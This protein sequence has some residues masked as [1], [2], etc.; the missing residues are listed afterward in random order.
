MIDKKK[1][2]Q[3]LSIKYYVSLIIISLASSNKKAA[4]VLSIEAT[5]VGEDQ[6]CKMKVFYTRKL[7]S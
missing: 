1:L 6:L 4:L 7:K 2:E 3:C 5:A